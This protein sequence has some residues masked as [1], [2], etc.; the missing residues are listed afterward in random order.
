MTAI[1]S[2]TPVPAANPL[3]P[4]EA[5]VRRIVA[6]VIFKLESAAH[7]G[8]GERGEVDLTLTRGADKAL[9]I[10]GSSIAGAA[11]SYLA[12]RLLGAGGF[13]YLQENRQP[14]NRA[15]EIA[16]KE[17]GLRGLEKDALNGALL[18]LFGAI[19]D[20]GNQS[21]LICYDAYAINPG[22]ESTTTRDGV[23]IDPKTNQSLETAR[24]DYEVVE[25]NTCFALRFEM[26]IR[27][28][29]AKEVVKLNNT[30]Q[31]FNE[32]LAGFENEEIRLGARTRRGLGRGKVKDRWQVQDFD[33]SDFANYV[34][35]LNTAGGTFKNLPD[36]TPAGVTERVYLAPANFLP[37]N[38]TF[39]EL[40]ATFN[41]TSSLLIRKSIEQAGKPDVVQLLSDG[42]PVMPGTSVAGVLRHRATQVVNTL[43]GSNGAY[44]QN[45]ALLIDRLFGTVELRRQGESRSRANDPV[46]KQVAGRL[47][48]EEKLLEGA[49]VSDE[50]EIQT[51]NRI[52]R[53]T[54]G[55]LEKYLFNEQPAWSKPASGETPATHWQLVCR[56]FE[57]T[58]A[59]IGLV[60]LLLKDLWLSDMAI[61][62]GGAIGRGVF[63]GVEA[64]LTWLT[65]EN[66]ANDG[67]KWKF[68]S[69]GLPG[70]PRL[71]FSEGA[72]K[73]EQ[74]NVF[75]SE[76]KKAVEAKNAETVSQG[77]AQAENRAKTYQKEGA[78]N[79]G[80]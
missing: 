79:D 54:G 36:P 48:V 39:F 13:Y 46:Y 29:L 15:R 62:G 47:R 30:L 76:L 11:R 49:L 24:Y 70:Q 72:D 21:A 33:F 25:R 26:V 17:A 1:D 38:R 67:S 28:G 18:E 44:K 7:F 73:L 14:L 59:E 60:L 58:G 27:Q 10:P 53:F 55:T 20:D 50:A 66:R 16:L 19:E 41:L 64:Q 71:N 51:R 45:A 74:L 12:Y 56:I 32:L 37:D 80:R 40:N 34:A 2:T 52:D 35:Y 61:G 63:D 43:A 31:L 22:E 6:R 57:P 4:N 3:L 77:Q 42:Q 65:A 5:V 68:K 75:V 69:E 8:G 23:A 9:I 78:D